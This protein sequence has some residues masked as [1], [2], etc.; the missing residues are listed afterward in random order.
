M[1]IKIFSQMQGLLW[2]IE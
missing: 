1:M 2:I